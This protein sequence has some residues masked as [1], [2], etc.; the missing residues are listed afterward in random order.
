MNIERPYFPKEVMQFFKETGKAG[1]EIHKITRSDAAL[2]VA[3]RIKKT[4]LIR[5]GYSEPEAL[6]QARVIVGTASA[7]HTKRRNDVEVAV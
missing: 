5:K 2:G 3:V 4:D 6:R 1:S 7:K